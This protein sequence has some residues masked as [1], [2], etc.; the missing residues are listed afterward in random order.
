MAIIIG[1][2]Q[3]AKTYQILQE[4]NNFSYINNVNSSNLLFLNVDENTNN[5]AVIR[6][7]NNYEIGYIDNNISIKNI[8]NLLTINN[9]NINFYKNVYLD[10]NI[11]INNYFYTSNNST[12]FNN[13]IKLNLNN[14]INNSF[15]IIYNNNDLPVFEVFKNKINIRSP[16]IYTSNIWLASNA[17]LY[18]N[19]IN[20]PNDQPVV[21]QNMSFA[22]NLRIFS[23]NIVQNI[24]LDNDIV[25]T[26]LYNKNP[27]FTNPYSTISEEEW[28]TYMIDNNINIKD[29]NFSKPNIYVC[30]YLSSGTNIVGGSNIVEFRTKYLNSS[31]S[32]LIF[33]INNKGYI[34]IDNKYNC[35]IPLNINITPSNSNII[36]YTN[37]NNSNSCYCI[38]SNGFINIGS[39]DFLPNQLNIYKNNNYDRNNTELISLNINNSNNTSNNN[40]T[41]IL[42][43]NNSNF[44]DFKLK[45]ST[46]YENDVNISFNITITNNYIINYIE[47]I[48]TTI[49]TNASSYISTSY[50]DDY[51]DDSFDYKIIL[52]IK[53]PKDT[54]Q[55]KQISRVVNT[56]KFMIYPFNSSEPDINISS[57]FNK[58]IY[59]VKSNSTD[60]TIE[61]Y[62]YI[63][64]Y[65]YSYTG[66]YYPKLCN[67]ISSKTNNNTIFE[68]S[69]NGNIGIG[70]NYTDMYNLYIDGNASINNI[71]C[72]YIDNNLTKNIS[73]SNCVLNNI[74]IINNANLIKTNNLISSNCF[75]SN[76]DINNCI[77]N[78]NLTI[79]SSNGSLIVKTKSIFGINSNQ[80]NN[81]LMTINTINGNGLVINNNIIN[82]N[83]N[84]L[85]NSSCELSYPYIKLQTPI[86]SYNIISSNNNFQI[87]YNNDNILF[88]NNSNYNSIS[89][90]N[91]SFNIFKDSQGNI[92]FYAGSKNNVVNWYD[93]ICGIGTNPN[94]KSSFNIYGNFKLFNIYDTSIISCY[95]NPAQ[96]NQI[97]IGFGIDVEANITTE[98]VNNYDVIINYNTLFTSNVSVLNN[99]YLTGTILSVSDCNLKTNIQ[100]IENPLDKIETISGYTYTRTD[101]GK[102]ETGLIAQEVLRI[103]PEVISYNTD[104]NYTIS[105]GNM[106]GILVESIKELNKKISILSDKIDKLEKNN[107]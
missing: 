45:F 54:L 81:Y 13:N 52:I 65:I 107:K 101:T 40:T 105:Y 80:Y 93:T 95:T 18:T 82:N 102:L 56:L 63:Y 12:F 68:I 64:D 100:K 4:N 24:A 33:T 32:N 30:K 47:P 91:N 51:N 35:N 86:N 85:I 8:S 98:I 90:L 97:K 36:Q 99:I 87:N 60:I 7:K 61:L 53:Y 96:F 84:L 103:L 75:L 57:L 74:D 25:F 49:Y 69:Q 106:C 15:K 26:D 9:N 41:N 19:F 1:V 23:A 62:I 104:N 3:S 42:F 38:N 79:L 43:K 48:N 92:K 78:S 89:L 58:F 73:F 94:N 14:N 10:S 37:I 17:V 16:D 77:I 70:T 39:L 71:N 11:N 31:D 66:K 67:L 83:P 88:E 27:S 5:N 59:I 46:P 34:S 29:P 22:E 21:I 72:K 6:F 2:K 44:S 55:I 50:A 20:S 76:L 28:D